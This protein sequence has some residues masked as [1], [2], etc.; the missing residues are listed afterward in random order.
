[1]AD[2]DTKLKILWPIYEG[3]FK[4]TFKTYNSDFS[5]V[6]TLLF[7]FPQKLCITSITSNMYIA[8]LGQIKVHSNSGFPTYT[9]V[10]IAIK[11]LTNT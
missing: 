10:C 3:I 4:E 9:P 6:C 7:I 2:E 1:M 8:F 5:S 11:Q